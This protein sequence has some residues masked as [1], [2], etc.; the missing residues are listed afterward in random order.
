MFSPIF[1]GVSHPPSRTDVWG[2]SPPVLPCQFWVSSFPPH[3]LNGAGAKAADPIS[4][5]LGLAALSLLSKQIVY[6]RG[7]YLKKELNVQS[8]F[9]ALQRCRPAVASQ[10]VG[11]CLAR[12][13]TGFDARLSRSARWH[14]GLSEHRAEN[15]LLCLLPPLDRGRVGFRIAS[16]PQECLGL[17]KPRLS[18]VVWVH[19]LGN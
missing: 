16:Y 12:P 13:R 7:L 14:E 15:V 5:A 1:S 10:R 4:Q 17:G 2:L 19:K 6:R 8:C 3:V 18:V 9:L 11:L